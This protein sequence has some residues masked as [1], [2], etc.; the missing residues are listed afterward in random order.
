MTLC[1]CPNSASMESNLLQSHFGTREVAPETTD[2]SSNLYAKKISKSLTLIWRNAVRMAARS[3]KKRP[4]TYQNLESAP[5]R[6][7]A[8]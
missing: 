3:L 2:S 4:K 7:Q 1:R 6:R 8:I 5:S